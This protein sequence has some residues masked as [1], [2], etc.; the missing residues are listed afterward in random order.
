V[1]DNEAG[2]FMIDVGT[3][4]A[5]HKTFVKNLV[6]LKLKKVREAMVRWDDACYVQPYSRYPVI[7]GLTLVGLLHIKEFHE[8]YR[9]PDIPWESLIR[10]MITVNENEKILEVFLKMQKHRYHLA[11]V[12]DSEGLFLGIVSLE[13]ILEEIVGD[14]HEDVESDKIARLLSWRSGFK[15]K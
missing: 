12:I 5:Y 11:M 8:A 3:L 1:W 13:D 4:P 9:E 2:S 6:S 10:P 7:D 15:I 14:I